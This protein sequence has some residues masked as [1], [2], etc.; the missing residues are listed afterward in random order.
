MVELTLEHSTLG[1]A[2]LVTV[3]AIGLVSVFYY[4]AFGKLRPLQ[5]Q[6]LLVLRIIAIVIVALLLFRPVFSY[7]KELEEKRTVILLVDRSASMSIADSATG[8]N[9]YLQACELVQRWWDRLKDT[10]HLHLLAFAEDAV[11]VGDPQQLATLR[12]DGKATSIT[13]GLR[14]ACKKAPR[15]E[16]EAVF[17]ISD[18]IH[19]S[20]GRPVD[21]AARLGVTIHT[22]GVGAT[23]KSDVSYRDVQVTGLDVAERMLINNVAKIKVSVEGVGLPGRVVKVLLQEDEKEI[24]QQDLRLD[25]VEGAQIVEFEFRPTVKGRHV[26]TARVEPVPE[27]RIVENNRR[28]A[29]SL[30]VE[31]GI[32]VL[33]LE[34]TIR[35]EI[36]AIVGRFL[37]KDPDLEFCALWQTKQN[38]FVMRSNIP[39]LALTE[40][41]TDPAVIN[42]FDVF[43]I[44]DLD[45]SFLRPEVQKLIMD[46]V[47]NGAG[48]MMLGGYHSLGPG[49]YAG[50]PIGEALP[51]VL[52]SR[53]I[54]QVTDEFLPQLTPEG[55]AHPIFANIADF[56]PT[57]Q[58]SPKV[59]GLPPLDGC[60]RVGA[61]KPDALVLATCPL[62][63]DM[64]V[65]AIRTQGKGRV[66]VFTADTT[67]KWQQ[68]PRALNQQSPFLQFWGQ[69]VRWLAGRSEE[70]K[71]EA[72]ITAATDKGY[73]E[74]EEPVRISAIV[75]DSRGEGARDAKVQAKI[76]GPGGRPDLVELTAI[77]GPAGHYS[78]TFEPK[79]PGPYEIDVEA[80]LTDQTISAE[81]LKIEVGRPNLEFEKLDLD[82]KMLAQIA[83]H[84]K[85]RYMHITAADRLVDQLDTAVRKRQQQLQAKLYWPPGFWALFVLVLTVE[86]ILRR[87]FQLR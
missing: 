12:P 7:Q 8:Q 57:K 63:N 66:A 77:P 61:A 78:G 18:G 37:A 50:T 25:E 21:E 62:E 80:R 23:L 69:V 74:P 47:E 43:L 40:I 31:P 64:P 41:P 48:L 45:S 84:A 36:G 4:F 22:V 56:F 1:M 30:V 76:R 39:Q 26:Y 20:I 24:A 14:A 54:G 46:R 82:E 17:L 34:G 85:G 55:V 58:R 60:T 42:T 38:N 33:Y 51:V 49:G 15:S 71:T 79:V 10:V 29:V 83:A 35:A 32:R 73:Y 5:W 68:G 28:S 53:D 72:S 3:T 59:E 11:D 16:I 67:R 70:V 52:G 13:R 75:R 87:R 44:G 65:L 6:T 2:L 27:E 19:N 86:W 81:K 9:R